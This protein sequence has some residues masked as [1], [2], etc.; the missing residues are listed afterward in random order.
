MASVEQHVEQEILET[1]GDVPQADVQAPVEAAPSGEI[2]VENPATGETVRT[3]PDLGPEAVAEMAA[4]GR[5]V[6]PEWEAYGFDGRA[7]VLLRAQKWL[8]DNAQRVAETIVSETGK[9]YEDANLAEIGYAGNAFGFWAKHGPEYLADESIKSSQVLVK[10]KKLIL[11]YRPLGLIGVIGPWNY[12][13]TNS[14]GDCIPALMAGNSV[15]LKPSEFTSLSALAMAEDLQRLFPP[16]V[17]QVLTGLGAEVGDALVRHP[18]IP[19]IAFIGSASTGRRIQASAAAS[20][21]KTVTLELGGKNPI[22]VFPDADLDLAVEGAIRGMNFTWQGQS[23]GSTS[24]LLVHRDCY[25]DFVARVGERIA[26]MRPG[27]P[28]D[29]ASDTGA[30]VSK[31]QLDKVLAYIEVGKGENARLVT[32][33]VRLTEGALAEGNFVSPA[34]FADVDPYGRLATEEIFG[35]VLA[36]IPFGDYDEALAIANSVEYGLTASVFTRDLRTALAFSRDVQAGY[37]WVNETARH[38]L[39]APFG[40]VKNSGVGREEDLS[41]IES[42]TQLKSVNIRF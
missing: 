23:C 34:L 19:R 7:R 20:G 33:G 30:I 13:L 21:V 41:E 15:I 26:A 37:V 3:V 22:V 39:G 38:F 25:D 16:G 31:Q 17:V 18:G 32:G 40:G 12:P 28:L 4:R 8:M 24:R 35:P 6:Q 27:S 29:P 14:F 1:N 2:P 10:G 11:R 9:T 5:R 36:A 42:Y